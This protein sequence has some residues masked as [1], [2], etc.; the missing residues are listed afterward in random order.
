[1][2]WPKYCSFMTLNGLGVEGLPP[3][4]QDLGEVSGGLAGRVRLRP[5]AMCGEHGALRPPGRGE[6]R[7]R[8][9][10]EGFWGASLVVQWLRLSASTAESVG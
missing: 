10:R 7:Q 3:R 6:R 2:R 9:D 5:G 4:H 1:M 8:L